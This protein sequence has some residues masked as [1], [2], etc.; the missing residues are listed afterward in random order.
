M[1]YY[2]TMVVLGLSS[3]SSST[4]SVERGTREESVRVEEYLLL[5]R[6]ATDGT[7]ADKEGLRE[8]E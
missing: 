6:V 3:D 2:H 5:E 1:K 7:P 8:R 4:A